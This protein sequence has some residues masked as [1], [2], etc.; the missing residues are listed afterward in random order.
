MNGARALALLSLTAL[1]T[2]GACGSG[3]LARGGSRDS[4]YIAVAAAM[5]GG[6]NRAYFDGVRLA[7]EHLNRGLPAGRRPFAVR[8]PGT[9]A[10][11][12]VAIAAAFRDDPAVIGV[13]GHTGSA[14]TLE[15]APIYGD[16]TGGGRRAV[17]AISPGAT[18]PAISGV[19]PWV[20]RD[21]PTDHDMAAA[22]AAYTADTLGRRR[23]GV[24]YRNDLFGRGFQRAFEAAFQ[25]RGGVVVEHDPYL[26]GITAYDAY[27]RRMARDGIQALIVAGGAA[28]A[29]PMLRALRAT[30]GDIPVVGTDDMASLAADSAAR[31]FRGVRYAAFYLAD[32]GASTEGARFEAEY[33]QRF[34]TE[35]DTRAA[36][37]Y[38]AAM[39]IGQ[40]AREVGP[41][42]RKVRDWV[43]SVGRGRAAYRGITGDIRFSE[44]GD[45]LGKPVFI[46]EVKP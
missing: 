40:A 23:V 20:F 15:A 5:S 2:A 19:S 16:V 17:V 35:P 9:G 22:M 8:V 46:T 31:E 34:G 37:G 13:V 6:S 38:D 27:A 10:A 33:R 14:Q 45:A 44:K 32:R 41:D 24:I 12:Q 29:E 39:I 42:R 30:L 43:A 26:T 3:S 36:L 21:C 1:A 4:V 11:T 7:V 18:N 25:A 28:D